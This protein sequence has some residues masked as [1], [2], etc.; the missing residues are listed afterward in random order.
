MD[1]IFTEGFYLNTVNPKAPAFIITNQSIHVEK[2]IAWLTANKNLADEKGYIKLVGKES[3]KLDTKGFP[4]R[5][6]EVDTYKK[7]AKPETAPEYP[8]STGEQTPF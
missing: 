1:S 3:K 7:E 8:E 4:I 6:F 2:A 5:Y